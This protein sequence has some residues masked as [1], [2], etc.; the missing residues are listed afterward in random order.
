M[1]WWDGTRFE[2]VGWNEVSVVRMERGFK[3]WEV[4][5]FRGVGRY[6]VLGGGV[7]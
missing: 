3:G 1:G 2:V 5:G 4:T 7:E 6:G